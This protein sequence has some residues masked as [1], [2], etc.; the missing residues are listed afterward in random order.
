MK[1]SN[2]LKRRR[3]PDHERIGIRRIPTSS[4]ISRQSSHRRRS[5]ASSA[6]TT[7]FDPRLIDRFSRAHRARH[8]RFLRPSPRPRAH[9]RTADSA[10]ALAR[11]VSTLRSL[12][13]PP[14]LA[15]LWPNDRSGRVDRAGTTRDARRVTTGEKPHPPRDRPRAAPPIKHKKTRAHGLHEYHTPCDSSPRTRGRA[16]GGGRAPARWARK[17]CARDRSTSAS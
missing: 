16:S 11:D 15:R 12:I 6:S 14:S 3:K 10:R 8:A 17:P 13:A 1:R 5:R 4:V 7:E 2:V 9:L